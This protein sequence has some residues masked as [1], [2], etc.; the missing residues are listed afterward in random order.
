MSAKQLARQRP[1]QLSM[2]GYIFNANTALEDALNP[3]T[4][5][6]PPELVEK[7]KGIAILNVYRA[8]A[9]IGMHYG[10]GVV[11]AKRPSEASAD[12]DNAS[13]EKPQ[14]SPPSAVLVNGF[15]MGALVGAKNDSVM[16]FIMDD[17]TMKDFAQ[18][19]Q[20][21]IGLEVSL[22]VGTFGGSKNIDIDQGAVSLTLTKGGFASL[23]LQLGTLVNQDKQNRHFYNKPKITPAQILFEDAVQASTDSQV[24]DL[25]KKLDHLYMGETWVATKEDIDR[26][27]RFLEASVHASQRFLNAQDA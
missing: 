12:D 2:E 18:R 19:P 24:P 4:L 7:C 5:T 16:V 25:Y 27:S 23:G 20:S 3:K 21:R 17:E 9:L 11:M 10:T 13:K 1:S 26:S 22:A 8:G 6:V 14:W 15:S